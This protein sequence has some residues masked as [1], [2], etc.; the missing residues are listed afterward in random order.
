MMVFMCSGGFAKSK[1][2]FFKL[3]RKIP[4]VRKEVQAEIAKTAHSIQDSFAADLK[5]GMRFLKRLP[6][7]GSTVVSAHSC[8]GYLV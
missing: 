5:P 4:I 6:M 3:V 8:R 7:K 1:R 2:I